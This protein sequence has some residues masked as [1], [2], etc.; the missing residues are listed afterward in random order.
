MKSTCRLCGTEWGGLRTEHCTECCQTFNSATAGD[1]HRTG[2][3]HLSTGPNRRR[4]RTE[5][6]MLDM[7]MT[8]NALGRWISSARPTEEW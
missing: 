8:R 7:G 6:E 2:E 4:C 1:M 3:H 5:A